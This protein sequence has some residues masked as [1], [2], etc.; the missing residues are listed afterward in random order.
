M[1]S[2]GNAS[3]C[4]QVSR[5]PSPPIIRPR[6]S[7]LCILFISTKVHIWWKLNLNYNYPFLYW[8]AFVCVFIFEAALKMHFEWC[9]PDSG[10]SRGEILLCQ[11]QVITYFSTKNRQISYWYFVFAFAL[12]LS[13]ARQYWL[14]GD[15]GKALLERLITID[16]ASPATT[17]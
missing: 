16:F 17:R 3:F 11:E 5:R 6:S 1:W 4:R 8:F 7:A 15:S 14:V 9:T 12:L 2:E 10:L 13:F